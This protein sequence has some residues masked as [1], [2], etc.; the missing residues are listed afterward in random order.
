MAAKNVKC[1]E[2]TKIKEWSFSENVVAFCPVVQKY[3]K[4]E[5]GC[6]KGEKKK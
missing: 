6:K 2:C 5:N 1:S 4:A 3:V